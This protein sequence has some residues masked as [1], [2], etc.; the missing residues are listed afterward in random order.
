[1]SRAPSTPQT[2]RLVTTFTAAAP[3]PKTVLILF[4]LSCACYILLDA[5]GFSGNW[6]AAVKIIPIVLLMG[7]TVK[8]LPSS[9]RNLMLVALTFSALGDVF[10]ALDI[11][12]QFSFGLGAFLLAQ[13][14]YAATFVRAANFLCLRFVLRAVPLLLVASLLALQLLPAVGTQVGYVAAYLV[15]ILVMVLTA[16]AHRGNSTLL[17]IGAITFIVSDTL[18]AINRFV[19]PLPLATI[20]IMLSY[21]SA[22]L[23]LLYGI[24]RARVY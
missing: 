22:Q 9:C 24:I 23:A 15:A 4:I 11:P 16:A 13:L 14:T 21:Y 12:N 8:R 5:R 7:I 20:S 2:G 19:I 1:M 17:F 10:L 6:M 18:I 3:R